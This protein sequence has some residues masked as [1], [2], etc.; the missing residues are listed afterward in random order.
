MPYIAFTCIIYI[1]IFL[2]LDNAENYYSTAT[3][4]REE[5]YYST[6]T[7]PPDNSQA[8]EY[9]TITRQVSFVINLKNLYTIMDLHW[10]VTGLF[11]SP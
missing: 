1:A 4:P 2:P 5:N 9:S 11:V 6:T 10:N 8:H 3:A 7:V